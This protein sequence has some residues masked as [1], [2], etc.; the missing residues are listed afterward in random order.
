MKNTNYKVYKDGKE[1]GC[2]YALFMIGFILAGYL[3]VA[4]LVVA[5]FITIVVIILQL[6]GVIS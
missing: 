2:L 3:L 6:L 1:Q 4:A 5:V